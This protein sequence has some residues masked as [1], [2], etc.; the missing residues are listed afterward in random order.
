[1]QRSKRQIDY[2]PILTPEPQIIFFS[3]RPKTKKG[4]E[5]IDCGD[6]NPANGREEFLDLLAL[7]IHF[8]AAGSQRKVGTYPLIGLKR[9]MSEGQAPI[10]SPRHRSF[11]KPTMLILS[12]FGSENIPG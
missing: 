7:R 10:F 3:S 11:R 6:S 9:P 2:H 8:P 4:H 12:S 5:F 1:V